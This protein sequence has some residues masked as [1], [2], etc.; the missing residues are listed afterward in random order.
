[1]KTNEVLK[2]AIEA[3]ES[4]RP[5]ACAEILKSL[6]DA[7]GR[8]YESN[9]FSHDEEVVDSEVLIKMAQTNAFAIENAKKAISFQPDAPSAA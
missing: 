4:G 8:G 3:S 1:M 9:F 6:L 5:G 2:I 7:M